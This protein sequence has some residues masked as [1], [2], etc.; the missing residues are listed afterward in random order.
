MENFFPFCLNMCALGGVGG[1]EIECGFGS[2]LIDED[3]SDMIDGAHSLQEED[4]YDVS[5]LNV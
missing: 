1:K 3:A 5:C 4:G 2:L